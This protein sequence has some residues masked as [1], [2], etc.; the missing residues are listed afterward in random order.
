MGTLRLTLLRHGHAEPVDSCREDFERAL[1]R[2]GDVQPGPDPSLLV[3]APS[4]APDAAPAGHAPLSVLEPP[5]NLAGGH[6]WATMP[7]R[8]RA[9]LLGGAGRHS[10][11]TS[12][13]SG[14]RVR[15]YEI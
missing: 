12:G 7:P 11:I 13:T 6:D 4:H 15:R 10:R 3:T 14:A 9:R 1:T 5:A 2:R 8:L